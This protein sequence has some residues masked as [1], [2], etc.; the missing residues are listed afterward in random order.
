MLQVTYK[1]TIASNIYQ[2][3]DR[4][5]LIDLRACASLEIPVN[6]CRI[7]LSAADLAITPG[8]PVTVELGYDNQLALVFTGMVS[9]VDWGIDRVLIQATSSF[10]TLVTARFNL[11]YEK[12]PAKEIV[13]DIC[14]R[15]NLSPG[16]IESGIEF[17]VYVLGDDRSVY[18]YLNILARQ[19]G[20]DFYAD[21]S[22]QV[23]F[24]PYQPTTTHSFQYSI[25]I[26][27]CTAEDPATLVTGVEIYGES[28]TSFGQGTESYAWFTKQDVQGKAGDDSGIVK[29]W[30]DPTARTLDAASQ[31]AVATLAAVQA[32]QQ[33][34]LRGL[35]NAAVKLGD[36]VEISQLPIASQNGT[37][38]ITQIVQILNAQQG[39][40]TVINWE[41][42]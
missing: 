28:P 32:K 37:F 5:R 27:S 8:D 17:P 30:V 12:S 16:Q 31:I 19:C 3:S 34:S 25:N 6:T 1:I 29:R 39:F 18:D 40:C 20:F 14:D 10:Q 7:I 4:T 38:K 41:E 9:S 22:D 15:L 24:A 33:G 13:E 23:I 21:P 26:L 2:S 11:L 36:A 35:G 42:F